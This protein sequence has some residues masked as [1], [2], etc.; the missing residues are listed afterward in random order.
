MLWF[1]KKA[2]APEITTLA[3]AIDYTLLDPRATQKDIANAINI[4]IKHKYYAVCVNSGNV[5]IAK[6]YALVKA[7]ENL[8]IVSVVGF[9]LGAQNLQ[10][11]LFEAKQ[12]LADGADELDVVINIGK[13]KEGDYD[14]IKNEL[15]RI[16]RQSKGKIVKAII[17]TCYFDRE[18]IT[19]ICKACV[20][21]KVDYIKTSTGYGTGGATPEVI[22]LI[23]NVT[24]GKCLV[25]ASGGI[26]SA[27]Q[28]EELVRAGASR[29]GTSTEI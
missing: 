3:S 21:A 11:K 27:S 28:A 16:V 29:I 7:V 8:N 12:A 1:K 10:T 2:V 25:K 23:S 14:Y 4:A 17:E 9:P 13:A 18:E 19:S 24:A 20:R 22:D 6:D 26:R 5:K 15:S